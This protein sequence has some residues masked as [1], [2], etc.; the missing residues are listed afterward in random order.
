MGV[1]RVGVNDAG[2][3]VGGIVKA[4]DELEAKCDEEGEAQQKIREDGRRMC[5]RQVGDQLGKNVDSADDSDDGESNDA[6]TPVFPGLQ[7]AVEYC[8]RGLREWSD[9]SHK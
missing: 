4:V 1:E 7:L 9:G 8:A 3:G 5:G 2:N 6:C